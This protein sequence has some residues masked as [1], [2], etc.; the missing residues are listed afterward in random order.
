MNLRDQ[1]HNIIIETVFDDNASVPEKSILK[2][3]KAAQRIE[4][5]LKTPKSTVPEE[6]KVDAKFVD[7][8][9]GV[10]ASDVKVSQKKKVKGLK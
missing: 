8:T 3:F 9:P 7:L 10:P 6:D 4:A 1:I 5:L 2:V